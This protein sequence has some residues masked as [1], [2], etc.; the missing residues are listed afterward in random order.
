MSDG[1][2]I[3]APDRGDIIWLDFSPQ[4]GREQAGRRPALT[5]SPASYNRRV[6]LGLFCPITSKIKG[7]P[8]EVPLPDGLVVSGVILDDQIKSIDWRARRA[9]FAASVPTETI[10]AV[11]SLLSTLLP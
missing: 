9:Q 3:A 2:P 8:F 10:D 11:A 4:L 7:Y 5:V 6:G 1:P